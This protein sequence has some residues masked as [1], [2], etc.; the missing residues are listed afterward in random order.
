MGLDVRA[1]EYYVNDRPDIIVNEEGKKML[2]RLRLGSQIS[3][4]NVD[5]RLKA[6]I[7]E[8]V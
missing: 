8:T 4:R 6:H 2:L 3:L 1:E 5:M 7:F